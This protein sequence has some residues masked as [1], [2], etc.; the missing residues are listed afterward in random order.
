MI[1]F[2][3]T[4]QSAPC[5]GLDDL[6]SNLNKS[7]LSLCRIFSNCSGVQCVNVDR[8]LRHIVELFNFTLLTCEQPSPAILVELLGQQDPIHNNTRRLI[9][10]QELRNSTTI[11]VGSSGIVLG[12]Y[13]FTVNSNIGS[14]GIAVCVVEILYSI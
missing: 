1:Y 13:Y 3:F 6:I 14:I 4:G 5:S 8:Q 11:P 10:R 7:E 12:A 2:E 9:Y